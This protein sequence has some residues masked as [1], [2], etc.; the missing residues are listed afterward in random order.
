MVIALPTFVLASMA[1][2]SVILDGSYSSQTLS[3]DLDICV[4]PNSMA[5]EVRYP[6]IHFE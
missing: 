5:I 1:D 2:K 6:H 3:D 4:Y